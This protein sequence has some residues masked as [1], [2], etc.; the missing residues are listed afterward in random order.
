M[1]GNDAQR[2]RLTGMTVVKTGGLFGGRRGKGF[3]RQFVEMSW[4]SSRIYSLGY[5]RKMVCEVFWLSMYLYIYID[6]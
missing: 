6:L 5:Y 1:P 4:V 3:T 2:Q